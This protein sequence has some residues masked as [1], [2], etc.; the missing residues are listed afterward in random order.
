M[1]LY[2]DSRNASYKDKA[3]DEIK[4]IESLVKKAFARLPGAD[5]KSKLRDYE[6]KASELRNQAESL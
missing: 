5:E 3:L 4:E 1:Q 2:I 6:I